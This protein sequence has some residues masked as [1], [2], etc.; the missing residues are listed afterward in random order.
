MNQWQQTKTEPCEDCG[1]LVE[2]E[3]EEL[4]IG[5]PVVCPECI[6]PIEDNSHMGSIWD[7][8]HKPKWNIENES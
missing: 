4:N 2:V 6:E 3:E 1:K 5:L 7:D 8:N